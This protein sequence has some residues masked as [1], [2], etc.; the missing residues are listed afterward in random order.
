MVTTLNGGLTPFASMSNPF[1]NGLLQPAAT[2]RFLQTLEGRNVFGALP[3]QPLK[4]MMQWNFSIQRDLGYGTLLQVGYA[5][6]AGRHL[7][8]TTG[9]GGGVSLDQIPD[10]A[11]AQYGSALLNQ[12]PNPFFGV[13]PSSVG[14]LGRPTVALGYLL[15]PYPQ[16]LNVQALTINEGDSNYQSLQITFQ[17]RFNAGGTIVANYTWSK[18]LS[19][20]ESATGNLEGVLPGWTQDWSNRKADY[21][22]ESTNVPRRLVV[23]YIYDLPF[24]RGKRFLSG[25]GG[26]TNHLIGGWS[27]NGV[28]TFSDGYPLVMTALANVLSSQFGASWGAGGFN[29]AMRPNVVP[30]CKAE[31]SGSAVSRLNEWF[32]TACYAQPGNV[33]FGN[34]SRTDPSLSQ[35]GIINFDAAINKSFAVREGWLLDFRSEFFNLANRV[36]FAAPNTQVGNPSFG[37]VTATAPYTTPRLVQLS[38]RLKF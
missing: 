15:R 33:S 2:P 3:D 38:L 9:G 1:P 31:I 6:N 16:F 26:L 4:Y 13:L 28:T 23:N 36:Q 25:V 18:F 8:V 32:N 24:G 27:I 19:D 30:G 37:I 35:Q 10:T 20:T 22:L 11:V 7:G 14:V 5:A 17:K 29:N 34:A 12:V 21:S